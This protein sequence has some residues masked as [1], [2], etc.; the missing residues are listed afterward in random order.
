M[1]AL[2]YAVLGAILLVAGYFWYVAVGHSVMAILAALVMGAGGAF[3]TA[4]LAV[5]LDIFSPTSRKV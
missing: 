3:I 1:R 2:I 5:A 4:G